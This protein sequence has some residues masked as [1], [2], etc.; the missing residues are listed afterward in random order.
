MLPFAMHMH[1]WNKY[2]AKIDYKLTKN[3]PP[4][5]KLT[6]KIHCIV[7]NELGITTVCIQSACHL[8]K[9]FEM[10]HTFFKFPTKNPRWH[11]AG[12]TT[13]VTIIHICKSFGTTIACLLGCVL[14]LK[15]KMFVLF[16]TM[17][18]IAADIFVVPFQF[19]FY[20]FFSPQQF[21]YECHLTKYHIS[22]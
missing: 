13:P 9:R 19:I 3:E 20:F 7:F 8:A 17:G 15:K 4:K 18:K 14:D 5:F 16:L 12:L 22:Q 6:V 21:F 11:E 2:F 1:K 10:W